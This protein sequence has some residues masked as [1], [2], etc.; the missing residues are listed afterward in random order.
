MVIDMNNLYTRLPGESE[1]ELILRIGDAKDQIGTWNDVADLINRLT[2]N[3]F[4]ES[5]YRKRYTTFK[6]MLEA[7]RSK[8]FV[9]SDERIQQID[10]KMR[11]L[12]RAKIQY[13][14]ERA[15][16]QK[17]NFA[18]A[19]VKEKLDLLESE[20]SEI[21]RREFPPRESVR[22]VDSGNDMLIL[23]SDFHIGKTFSSFMGD[24]DSEIAAQ[25]LAQLLLEVINIAELH[26]TQNC[27]VVLLG[28]MINGNIHK[29]IQVTNRENVIS[30]V[31]LA[32]E[33]I[34]SFCY[35][36]TPHF[37]NVNLY[38]VSGNHSRIDRK[39]DA[40][41]DE[42]LDD[43]IGWA[44]SLALNGIDNFHFFTCRNLDTGIADIYIR[45]KSYIAVHGDYDQFAKSGAADLS[46]A[47][48]FIPYAILMGHKHTC[49]FD[50]PNGVRMIRGGSL[51]GSGDQFTIEKRLNGSPS[52]MVCICS[53][54][55]I[56][57][58]Y[59]VELT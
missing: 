34:A 1:E 10:A 6:K 37:N 48:G 49:A 24:Y 4:G 52:Q 9:E 44:V 51:D 39:E 21:G 45:G 40:I 5:T 2:G 29:S 22:I 38:S 16:W 8:L 57:A 36:L 53:N 42:R 46:M 47:L 15:A 23:L 58:L 32:S 13:R 28:D 33:L 19:R 11:E 55:G 12:E 3:D 59:P 54:K 25:R 43:L 30:Q 18:D 27:Y 7:N 14:D 31:K 35:E 20:L 26:K 50:V 56:R 17:Q 41:H